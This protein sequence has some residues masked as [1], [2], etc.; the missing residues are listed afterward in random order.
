MSAASR[1]RLALG[2]CA[3]LGVLGGQVAR[4]D[5]EDSAVRKPILV[6]ALVVHAMQ[7]PGQVDWICEDLKRKLDMMNF[8]TLR[9]LQRR[10]FKLR[11]GEE[12]RLSLPAGHEVRFLP[13]SILNRELHMQVEMPGS[14]NT[15]MR[16]KSGRGVILGGIQHEDGHLIVHLE[17]NFRVPRAGSPRRGGDPALHRVKAPPP[18]PS[19]R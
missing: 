16:M 1:S 18:G 3:L 19:G 4:A 2:V 13:I 15:R 9:V 5:S 14:V 10:Q 17:P 6:R 12:G 11:F 7:K 8:G